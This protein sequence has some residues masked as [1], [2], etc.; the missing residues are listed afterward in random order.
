MIFNRGILRA[1]LGSAALFLT[2]APAIAA[3]PIQQWTQPNGAKVF[4]VE[5]PS[6]PIVDVQID[7][8]AGARR[9]P[10]DKPGLARATADMST[11]GVTPANPPAGGPYDTAMDENRISE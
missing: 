3:L 1:A 6:I 8:D 11:K 10:A 7:F 4:F 5:S 2:A 9:D